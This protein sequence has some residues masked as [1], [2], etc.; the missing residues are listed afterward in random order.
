MD[1]RS[2]WEK[3]REEAS[4]EKEQKGIDRKKKELLKEKGKI[5]RGI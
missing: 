2:A 3:V 1:D 4:E 5:D